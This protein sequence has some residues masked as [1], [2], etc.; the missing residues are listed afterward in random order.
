MDR[1]KKT[2]ILD[3]LDKL[4]GQKVAITM[5]TGLWSGKITAFDDHFMVLEDADGISLLKID[6][7]IAIDWVPELKIV[8]P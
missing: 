1:A 7:I 3:F 2:I 5:G 4:R 8:A 6:E